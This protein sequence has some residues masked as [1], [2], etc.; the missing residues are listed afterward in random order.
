M[1]SEERWSVAE[2]STT[3]E[4]PLTGSKLGAERSRVRPRDMSN[5]EETGQ[6]R[7]ADGGK[8][9]D[10]LGSDKSVEDGN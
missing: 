8:V 6:E 9:Q 7:R 4:A 10:E 5:S 3:A 2:G 1:I